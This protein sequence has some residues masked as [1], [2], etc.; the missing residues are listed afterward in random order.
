MHFQ[1]HVCLRQ[2]ALAVDA[3]QGAVARMQQ[4]IADA[5]SEADGM[6][7]TLAAVP[8]DAIL[9]LFHSVGQ[10]FLVRAFCDMPRP[11][12]GGP[13]IAPTASGEA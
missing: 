13:A 4:Q 1:L 6:I 7:Q 11:E 5:L 12:R 3:A 10:L 2:I 8:K 9:P